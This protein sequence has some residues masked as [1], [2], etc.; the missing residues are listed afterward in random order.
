M[1][2]SE[3]L[4]V[5][6][7]VTLV[8]KAAAGLRAVTSY[9]WLN[10]WGGPI[11]ESFSGAWQRNVTIDAQ[12]SL[13]AFSAVYACVTGIASDIAKMRIKLDINNDGIWEEITTGLPWLP[14]L[15]KPNH[16]QTR[17]K[18][19]QQ[20]MVSKL[21][22]GNAYILK[23]RQDKRGIVTALYVLDP[24]R[25]TVLVADDGS[26]YYELK[27]DFLSQV[28][29]VVTVPASE[30][31]HDT[32]VGLWHQLIGVS[33]LYAC[34]VSATMG[35][36][37]QSNSTSLF[38]NESRPGGV[39]TVPGAIN[40]EQ[41]LRLKTDWETNYGG[42][43]VGRVAILSDGMKFDPVVL[44]AEV[45]QLIEQ[46]RWTVEDVAR[47]FHYPMD[48]LG[49]PPPPYSSNAEART[50]VYYTDC[51]QAHIEDIELLLDE[52]LELDHKYGTEMDLDN[53]WRMDSTA[54]ADANAKAVGSGVMSPNEARFR[55][56]LGPVP[57]GD[58][59]FLQQQNYSLEA[60]SKRDAKDDPFAGVAPAIPA[61]PD[62]PLPSAKMS[63]E[64]VELFEVELRKELSWA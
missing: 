33:P 23:Q 24:T 54:L 4:I 27:Q 36:R 18:F 13:L 60:L 42:A 56:N 2:L 28:P 11:R 51:L 53:L 21:L 50:M 16:Y 14:V 20:W 5:R 35:N 64:D 47:A 3:T 46:L 38:G 49:G 6:D 37:I 30:I 62:K 29:E 40:K 17:I 52:G 39:V 57:G 22:F 44:S 58:S 61:N 45:M 32:M 9:S 1:K 15:R 63:R 26:L 31:I 25:V 55:A 59:P 8:R 34:G 7:V 12:T 48:K 19:I 43:N 41:A 10:W